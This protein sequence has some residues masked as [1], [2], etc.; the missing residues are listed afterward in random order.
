MTSG[1]VRPRVSARPPSAA[2]HIHPRIR[3]CLFPRSQNAN[4]SPPFS[5]SLS[6]PHVAVGI[7][8]V[9]PE[10]T[11]AERRAAVPSESTLEMR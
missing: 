4:I 7:V 9:M 8:I 3:A 2:R 11:C 10:S 5:L 6:L 1:S